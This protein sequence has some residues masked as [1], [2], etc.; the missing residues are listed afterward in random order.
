MGLRIIALTTCLICNAAFAA[1]AVR[2]EATI[3][4]GEFAGRIDHLAVDVARKR[5]FV[6][7]LGADRVAVLDVAARTVLRTID[8]LSEPQGVAYEPSTDTLYVANGGDG[9]VRMYSAATFEPVGAI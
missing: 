6:A 4:L 8:G 5:L 3:P 2:H 9:S 1:D 7:Q